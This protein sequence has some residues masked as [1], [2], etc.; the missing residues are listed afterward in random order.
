M[1]AAPR[2]SPRWCE[3]CHAATLRGFPP[4]SLCTLLSQRRRCPTPQAATSALVH[5]A[6]RKW[7]A[8]HGGDFCD[9]VTALVA[10]LPL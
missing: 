7:A 4:A 3:M 8:A 9:D 6:R 5:A 10:F 1:A 2:P